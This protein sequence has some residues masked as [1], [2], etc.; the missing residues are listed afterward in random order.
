MAAGI[1]ELVEAG[2]DVIVD[3]IGH[4]AEPIFQDGN[5]AQAAN[6]AGEAGIPFFSAFGNT[7]ENA[8]EARN[9]FVDY[10]DDLRFRNDPFTYGRIH[11]FE[12]LNRGDMRIRVKGEQT[13]LFHWDEPFASVDGSVGSQS[14]M[15]IFLFDLEGN[16]AEYSDTGNV[17]Q[18]AMETVD[19]KCP[20]GEV[21]W[22]EIVITHVSGPKPSRM[23]ILSFSGSNSIAWEFPT[24]TSTGYGHPNARMVAGVGASHWESSPAF[25]ASL[26]TAIVNHYSSL[27]GTPILFDDSGN[28]LSVPDVRKQPLFTG[29]DGGVTTFF[30]EED[31]SKYR[32]F[33]T[34]A[35][36]P[37]VAA[38]AA[39][40][41]ELCPQLSVKQVY[42]ILGETAADMDNPLTLKFDSGFDLKTGAG[43]VNAEAA[44]DRVALL[45]KEEY[46]TT[47]SGS[48]KSLGLA[49]LVGVLF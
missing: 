29:P 1:D 30:G 20:Y 46:A 2:C 16:L 17:G 13:L 28:R 18:D 8:W 26:N 47:S 45:C 33:G 27:G 14:D 43:M 9:G 34:S 11:L 31:D 21:C 7:G 22:R 49:W 38:V 12:G 4:A 35:A 39:L 19:I 36:A 25:N 48:L 41:L 15:D 42:G 44:L 3:D 24:R 5:I 37:H 6:R 32:F 10:G 23:K 40:M